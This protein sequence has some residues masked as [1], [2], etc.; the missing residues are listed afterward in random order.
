MKC[1]LSGVVRS[2]G[3]RFKMVRGLRVVESEQLFNK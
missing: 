2:P 3:A 1:S